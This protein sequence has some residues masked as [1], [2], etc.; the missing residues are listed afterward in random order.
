ML[1]LVFFLLL[2]T[3]VLGI[4]FDKSGCSSYQDTIVTSVNVSNDGISFKNFYRGIIHLGDTNSV[5]CLELKPSIETTQKNNVFIKLYVRNPRYIYPL[6]YQYTTMIVD[7]DIQPKKVHTS[8]YADCGSLQSLRDGQG[9]GLYKVLKDRRAKTKDTKTDEFL[10][11][12]NEELL[13]PGETLCYA[14]GFCSNECVDEE[15]HKIG[16]IAKPKKYY[17]IYSIREGYDQRRYDFVMDLVAEVTF[18]W[19]DK[20]IFQKVQIHPMQP[21]INTPIFNNSIGSFYFY[22]KRAGFDAGPSLSN[23]FVVGESQNFQGTAFLADPSEINSVNIADCNKVGVIQCRSANMNCTYSP[24]C[25]TYKDSEFDRLSVDHKDIL[26]VSFDGYKKL[27]NLLE[28]VND[29]NQQRIKLNSQGK[30]SFVV[31][32]A[33]SVFKGRQSI[34]ENP[35]SPFNDLQLWINGSYDISLIETQILPTNC[36]FVKAYRSCYN[37]D[38]PSILIIQAMSALDAGPADVALFDLRNNSLIGSYLLLT[39]SIYLNTTLQEIQIKL[40]TPVEINE[41]QIQIGTSTGTCTIF[42]NFT[43]LLQDKTN[44]TYLNRPSGSN[45]YSLDLTPPTPPCDF[46]CQLSRVDVGVWIAIGIGIVLVAGTVLSGGALLA[47]LT[48]AA[49]FVGT[50]LVTQVIPAVLP[51]LVTSFIPSMFAFSSAVFSYIAVAFGALFCCSIFKSKG[52]SSRR[53]MT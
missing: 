45:G 23:V 14:N 13:Y 44:G 5:A 47:P 41:I 34:Q 31:D 27:D 21:L 42:A 16:W 43:A 15:Y 6:A 1:I 24:N 51:K 39:S 9:T 40:F 8:N 35:D 26:E 38:I 28:I 4:E 18:P 12:T 25:Y 29:P 7:G 2:V 48:S 22:V 37:C 17:N 49:S 10:P 19:L 52:K 50:K 46:F 36:S 30:Y 20:T 33:G 53:Y 32:D 11:W 3:T